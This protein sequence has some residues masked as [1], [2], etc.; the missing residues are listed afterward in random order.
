MHRYKK[1][2]MVF[3]DRAFDN[4]NILCLAYLP[5]EIS[6]SLRN[7]SVQNL[8]SISGDPRQVVL[9]VIR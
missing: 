5:Y 9:E 8:F 3:G 6:L 7:L 2:D 1:V 4:F